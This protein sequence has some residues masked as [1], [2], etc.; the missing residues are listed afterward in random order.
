MTVALAPGEVLEFIFEGRSSQGGAIEVGGLGE[1][2]QLTFNHLLVSLSAVAIA[3]LVAMPLALYLG[4]IGRF[5]FIALAAANV[6]RAV[7][8]L[9]LVAFFIAFVGVGFRNVLIALTLLAIPPIITNTF[10]GVR[11][12]D[13]EIVDA[14][15]GQGLGELAIVRQVELPLAVPTIFAGLRLSTVT[16][17]ATAIIAPLAAYETLGEPIISYNVYALAGAVAAAIIVTLLTLV[18]DGVLA[19]LQRLLTPKGLKIAATQS[20]R[21]AFLYLPRRRVTTS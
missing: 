14:A 1:L 13:P 17:L 7:P 4:H 10:V 3:V 20:P 18:V 19:A 8:V 12:V 15:R 11:Q 5:Q 2:G 16:V 21:R 6:G 9:A